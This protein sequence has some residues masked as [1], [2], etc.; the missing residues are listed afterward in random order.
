MAL[1]AYMARDGYYIAAAQG[2]NAA[3]LTEWD[4]AQ[5]LLIVTELKAI[6]WFI[7]ASV[8]LTK[9]KTVSINPMTSTHYPKRLTTGR[10]LGRIS[11]THF[12]QTSILSYYVMGACTSV[13]A[14]AVRAI[15]KDTDETPLWV[16][17]HLEKEGTNTAQRKDI[18]GVVPNNL[19][20]SCSQQ[21]PIARQTYTGEFS[22]STPAQATNLAQPTALT[23]ILHPPFTWYHYASGSGTSKF[24]YNSATSN[25]N[26]DIIGFNIKFGWSGSIFGTYDANGYPNIG[27]YK[28]PF[29]A[30]VTLDC[31]YKDVATFVDVQTISDLDHASYAGDLDLV[32]DF[33]E[34][35][36]NYMAFT[37]DD[38]YIDPNSFE[39]VWQSEGDWFDGIRFDLVFR[40][41]S[42]SLAL[43]SV[44]NL[45]NT[46]YANP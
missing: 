9:P 14:D 28:P 19:N 23:Q 31:V 34:D 44:D 11:S 42:S 33:Y 26:V 41:E 12:L 29:T 15:T 37:F 40:N 30:R 10:D 13:A 22:Y 7:G 27:Y 24:T 4:N 45:G 25:I 17:F 21:Q 43:S 35:A 39:E 32:V 46:Y 2:P 38:M 6:D 3:G 1:A 5:A 8:K 36:T 20:I 18:M 16:G